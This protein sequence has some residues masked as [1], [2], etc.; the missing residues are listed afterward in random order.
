MIN[1]DTLEISTG[2]YWKENVRFKSFNSLNFRDHEIWEKNT[3]DKKLDFIIAN[4]VWSHVKY[5]YKKTNNVYEWVN[6]GGYFFSSTFRKKHYAYTN[7]KNEKS[8]MN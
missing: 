7:K 2:E 4:K 6:K 3:L 8:L 1:F 5:R